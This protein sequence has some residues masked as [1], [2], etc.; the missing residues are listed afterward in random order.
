M[1][2]ETKE[3]PSTVA[4][5]FAILGLLFLGLSVIAIVKTDPF[6]SPLCFT[7]GVMSLGFCCFPLIEGSASSVAKILGVVGLVGWALLAFFFCYCLIW[8]ARGMGWYGNR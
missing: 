6:S 7:L 8:T 2:I 3:P 4:L 1:D 5:V